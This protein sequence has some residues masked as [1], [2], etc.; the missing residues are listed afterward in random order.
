[1]RTKG[2]LIGLLALALVIALYLGIYFVPQSFLLKESSTSLVIE[3]PLI[4]IRDGS[5]GVGVSILGHSFDPPGIRE[6][7][8]RVYHN[9]P[10]YR[11]DLDGSDVTSMR[12]K[13]LYFINRSEGDRISPVAAIFALSWKV[14]GQGDHGSVVVDSGEFNGRIYDSS[15]YGLPKDMETY[16]DTITG[17]DTVVLN[18][19]EIDSVFAVGNGSYNLVMK[20]VVNY[21]LISLSGQ[22]VSNKRNYT[23]FEAEIDYLN[24]TRRNLRLFYPSN[25]FTENVRITHPIIVRIK[26]AIGLIR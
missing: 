24:G 18:L 25:F 14:E 3:H 5:R 12:T 6:F 21:T 23:I 10:G 8:S 9:L 15:L 19:S 7:V 4:L 11:I 22:S 13:T 16:T 2:L 17:D 1:M 20:G 26:K